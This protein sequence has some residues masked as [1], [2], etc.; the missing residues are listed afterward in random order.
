MKDDGWPLKILKENNRHKFIGSLC[1]IIIILTTHDEV[2]SLAHGC[3]RPSS[4]TT[5]TPK[6]NTF[7]DIKQYET[8]CA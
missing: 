3:E 5:A 4:A 2:N 6:N 8:K 7:I 1:V